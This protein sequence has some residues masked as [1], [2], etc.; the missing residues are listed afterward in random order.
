MIS[1]HLDKLHFNSFHGVHEEEK[2][3]GN[4][5]IVDCLINFHEREEVIVHIDDTINYVAVYEIIK[6]HMAIPTNLLETVAMK[7]GYDIHEKFPD[8]KCISVSITKLHPPIEA[9]QGSVGVK[10]HKEF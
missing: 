9:I 4:E 1:I 8:V 3:L 6:N 7:I 5:Y 10:W 2:I